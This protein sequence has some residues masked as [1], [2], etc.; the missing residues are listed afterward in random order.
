MGESEQLWAGRIERCFDAALAWSPRIAAP[1]AVE[2]G[3]SLAGD[4]KELVSAPVRTAAWSGLLS[5]VDHLALMTDL[6]G[7]DGL[8]MRPTSLYTPARAALLGASQAVWVLGGATRAIRRA[9][10]LAIAEDERAQHRKFLWDYTNDAYAK[11]NFSQEIMAEMDDL[12]ARLTVEISRIRALQKDYPKIDSDATS[13]MRD[14]A[15]HLTKGGE[16]GDQWMRFA[17]AYEWRVASAAAHGRSWPV[18]VRN[19]EKTKTASGELRSFTTTAGELGRA[20]GAATL[21]T[22]EAWRLWDLRR[23]NHL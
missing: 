6:R 7:E 20:V 10:A 18:F 21:M 8:T 1:D 23:V 3:S 12:A 16:T 19:T 5:A 14:A 17:L 15:E 13:M 22:S 4:D 9:R 11:A 2:P